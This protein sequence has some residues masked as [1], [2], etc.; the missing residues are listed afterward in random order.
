MNNNDDSIIIIMAGGL[1]SRMNSDIPKVLHIINNKPII[2][3]IIDTCI[4]L[5]PHKICIIVGKYYELIKNTIEEY[6]KNNASNICDNIKYIIQD[7]PLGTGHAILSC[8]NFLNKLNINVNKCVI[9]S[10]DVPL[11]QNSTINKLLNTY[12]KANILITNINDPSGYGRIKYINNKFY[13]IIEEKDCSNEEKT[14]TTI[15]GG[16]YFF[17]ID[18]LL[19]YISKISNNNN[20]NEYYLTDIFEFMIKDNI[21]IKTTFVDNILEI[22]GINTQKQLLDLEKSLKIE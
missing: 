13:K 4:T 10:G 20:Q 3:N 19:K 2:V 22:T 14:I 7:E 5:N 1:G 16:I 12:E 6:Y 9:L 21:E 8:K 15:N 11:I 18:T 17:K